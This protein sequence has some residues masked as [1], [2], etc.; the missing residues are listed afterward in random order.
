MDVEDFSSAEV[1]EDKATFNNGR[2]VDEDLFQNSMTLQSYGSVILIVRN[3]N[4]SHPYKQAALDLQ[5]AQ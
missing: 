1:E 5:G 2:G 3:L 4:L